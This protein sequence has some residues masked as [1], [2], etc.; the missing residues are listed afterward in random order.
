[1]RR[2]IGLGAEVL[3]AGGSGPDP[4]RFGDHVVDLLGAA[5]AK[6]PGFDLDDYARR[7][8]RIRLRDLDALGE[9]LDALDG[10]KARGCRVVFLPLG[11]SPAA[12]A[13]FPARLSRD[14]AGFL[15]RLSERGFGVE[16]EGPRLEQRYYADAAH[17]G[18]VGRG[19]FSEWL[20]GR[21][22]L[23]REGR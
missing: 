22:P 4:L 5:G 8:S 13:I 21:L 6:G 10:L 1:M 12:D 20:A 11:R 9:V 19:R 23:W 16:R 18:A 15:D 7:L 3:R 2:A 14:F 17:F